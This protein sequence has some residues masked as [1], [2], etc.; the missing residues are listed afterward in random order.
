MVSKLDISSVCMTFNRKWQQVASVASLSSYG[1]C[2][3]RHKAGR[4]PGLHIHISEQ[5]SSFMRGDEELL[6]LWKDAFLAPTKYAT[7]Q[8]TSPTVTCTADTVHGKGK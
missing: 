2:R 3:C 1:Q 8:Y 6:T 5:T 4:Q 7:V